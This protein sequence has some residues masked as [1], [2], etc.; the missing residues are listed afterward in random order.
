MSREDANAA[1]V[2]PGGVAQRDL[3]MLIACLLTYDKVWALELW[4]CMLPRVN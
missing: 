2:D 3:F 1:F 4:K